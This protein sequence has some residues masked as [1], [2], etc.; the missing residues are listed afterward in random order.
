MKRTTPLR[1]AIE[2]LW[3]DDEAQVT[4]ALDY[5]HNAAIDNV[6][7]RTAQPALIGLLVHPS[8][9]VRKKALGVIEYRAAMG[10]DSGMSVP[11]L[12]TLQYDSDPELRQL[13]RRALCD[14]NDAGSGGSSP[15]SAPSSGSNA[16]SARACAGSSRPRSPDCGRR[17]R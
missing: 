7:L 16:D 1:N 12:V 10:A 15:A 17:A 13:A 2:A 14:A 6:D 4:A 8:L 3:S 5:L 9:A 11:M